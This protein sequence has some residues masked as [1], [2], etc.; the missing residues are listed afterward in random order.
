MGGSFTPQQWEWKCCKNNA[1]IPTTFYA[2]EDGTDGV[3]D[4]KMIQILQI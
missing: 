2:A 4:T 1:V 3:L